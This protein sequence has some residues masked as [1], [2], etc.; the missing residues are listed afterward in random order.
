MSRDTPISPLPLA[1][2]RNW[3]PPLFLL[4]QV[5]AQDEGA[6]FVLVQIDVATGVDRD[7]LAPVDRRAVRAALLL[8]T[9][10]LGRDEIGDLGRLP[11]VADVEDPQPRVEPGDVHVLAGL[12]D[13]R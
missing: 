4:R 3:Q 5:E 2:R 13:R 11:R 9:G 8:E 10:S 12:L 6:P 1:E 7:L